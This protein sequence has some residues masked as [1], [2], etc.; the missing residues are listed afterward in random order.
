MAVLL[1]LSE[2]AASG[3]LLQCRLLQRLWQQMTSQRKI[4]TATHWNR[5][6]CTSLALACVT[7]N[8]STQGPFVTILGGTFENSLYWLKDLGDVNN[9]CAI[10]CI[11]TVDKSDLSMQRLGSLGRVLFRVTSS[12]TNET[13]RSKCH[14][15]L[16]AGG[17]FM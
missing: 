3:L 11:Q 5:G 8:Q 9:H 6:G 15:K 13:Q 7:N 12:S 10:S 4:A 17:V 2:G 14:L 1:A 16:P